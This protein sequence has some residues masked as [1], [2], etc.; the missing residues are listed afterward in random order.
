MF[1]FDFIFYKII[2]PRRVTIIKCNQ[3]VRNKIRKDVCYSLVKGRNFVCWQFFC[4]I[5]S[6]NLLT[7]LTSVYFQY[8][9]FCSPK[10]TAH[11][12]WDIQYWS[13]K[14]KSIQGLDWGSRCVGSDTNW[15]KLWKD[16]HSLNPPSPLLKGGGMDFLKI[17]QKGGFNF[18]LIRGGIEKRKFTKLFQFL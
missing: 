16:V 3:F 15:W 4:K 6:P 12:V 9:L 18:F 11:M 7:W 14:I 13:V 5:K 1:P 17:D 2:H 8:L 10:L